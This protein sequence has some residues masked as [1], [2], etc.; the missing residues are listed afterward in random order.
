MKC[1]H[2]LI[3]FY[4]LIFIFSPIPNWDLE[5]ISEKVFSSESSEN[6]HQYILYNKNGYILI[7]KTSKDDGKIK[8]KNY[9]SYYDK[10]TQEVQF[11]N[12]ESTYYNEL[13]A[14]ILICPQGKFHPYDFENNNYIIPPSFV[15]IGN[16]DL[17]CYKH[18]NGYF[19]IFY[20]NNGDYSAYFK[21]DN[22]EIGRTSALTFDLFAY[23]LPDCYSI[24]ENN[25]NYRMPLIRKDGENL[26][27]SG[28][29]LIMNSD[30]S[31]I[32]GNQISGNTILT[33]IKSHTRAIIDDNYYFYYFTYND[34]SD[35]TSGYSNTYL[36]ISN[37][38]YADSFSITNN[39]NSPL[40][41]I[42]NVEILDMNF[43]KGTHYVYYK[44]YN[45]NKNTFYY[46]LI[47][48]KKNKV[49]YN[50]EE[51]NITFIPGQDDQMT[52]ITITQNS[53][54]EIFI[55]KNKDQ[56]FKNGNF[57]LDVEG[58]K[59]QEKCEDGKIKMIPEEICIN[60]NICDLN[61]Y[62]FNDE[63]FQCG[64]CKDLNSNNETFKLINAPG[65]FNKIPNTAEYYNE[66][67]KLLKC[68]KNYHLESNQC[69]PDFCYE[70]CE[71]CNEI[72]NNI[73]SQKCLSCKNG[74][75][76]DE[77]N[78]CV[79]LPTTIPIKIKTTV[80]I[81]IPTT[82][83]ST[84]PKIIQ[85]TIPSTIINPLIVTT[86]PIAIITSQ[87]VT[88]TDPIIS[89]I[90]LLKSSVVPL[91]VTTVPIIETTIPKIST[92]VPQLQTTNQIKSDTIHKI[93]N[94]IS[95]IQTT[96]S[97]QFLIINEKNN[98][99]V[100]LDEIKII[101]DQIN[102]E[103]KINNDIYASLTSIKYYKINQNLNK[104]TIDL[105]FCENILRDEYNISY[106]KTLYILSL[107]IPIEGYKIPKIEYEIYYKK[108]EDN[109]LILLNLSFCKNEK[110]EI[111]MPVSI[112][113]NIDIYNP[114]SGYYND[115]CYFY[116]TDFGTDICLKDRREEFINKN[117]AICEENCEFKDYNYINKKVKC[118][119]EI[120]P[121]I[122]AFK[123]VKFNIRK[124]KNNFKDL[125]NVANIK[126][127]LCYK[128]VFKWRNLIYNIGF[129]IM[130][131]I[132]L[133]YFIFL[134]LFYSK[135]YHLYL[136]KIKNVFFNIKNKYMNT[137][138]NNLNKNQF[139]GN[140]KN[141][142]KK[143]N[144]LKRILVRIKI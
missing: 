140:K 74:F 143:R 76:L 4:K 12:I 64:L 20:T 100:P 37:S 14:K 27:L 34:I 121:A 80:P 119:C 68:K 32:N 65:C 57:I 58:N 28:Y 36:D 24:R 130:N 98:F 48:I 113:D 115:L 46:G 35:F 89:T 59:C 62:I 31:Y 134:I 69:L 106:N 116:K 131:F 133:L 112:D 3:F 61:F 129:Y 138:G 19:I 95:T 92:T 53:F 125:N 93:Q 79:N 109:K 127:L 10:V 49:L 45:T 117:L 71:T 110:I 43:I 118:S 101:N 13:G 42:D 78:N 17:S 142:R 40:S 81:I 122:S 114:K 8:S 39:N 105:G 136:N 108:E 25:Y 73:D 96:D 99:S 137:S 5:N 30:E 91:I 111:S 51:D 77:N 94:N 11:E 72:S 44:I 102:Y 52:M 60:K 41:F 26:I 18:V 63:E 15:E 84:I 132:F 2:I 55:I 107:E 47:D 23:K 1:F 104:T 54:Y 83:S 123:D 86:F 56:C 50:F 38:N 88:T 75:I 6:E 126:F 9:L 85:N 135:F 90:N 16:W 120:K 82:I 67:Q 66:Y 22:N 128:I 139:I 33:Q 144:I 21:K 103:F 87:I 7:K 97:Y 29:S 70:R 124:L 141:Q